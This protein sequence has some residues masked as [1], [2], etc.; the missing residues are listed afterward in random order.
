MTK[1]VNIV[2]FDVPLPANYGG[3]IDVYCKIK[4][5]SDLGVKVHLHCFQYGRGKAIQLESICESVTYYNRKKNIIS[6]FSQ[7][8][9]IV[10][11]R[12]NKELLFNLAE[13]DF[14]ILFEGLHTTFFLSS[15]KLRDRVKLVRTHN[16]EHDYYKGLFD[17]ER[18]L[19]RRLFFFFEQKKL[20]KYE[21]NLSSSNS[22]I[23]LSESDFKYF[24]S[25]FSNVNLIN[26]FHV[27]EAISLKYFSQNYVFYHA[28]LSISENI[29]ALE[30]L[31]DEV[32]SSIN[33]PII[34]AGKNPSKDLKDKISKYN[35]IKLIESPEEKVMGLLKE[36]A[37]VHILYTHQ[38]TG[39]KLKLIDSL[40]CNAHCIVNQKMISGTKLD[41]AC[42]VANS[43]GEIIDELK[44]AW[45]S[46]EVK[47]LQKR[48]EL[49][50]SN[51][52]NNN[53][54]KL[55]LSILVQLPRG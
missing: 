29:K 38:S 8:P 12:S 44:L 40:F 13:N 25:R 26:V 7:I 22:I 54:A 9:F 32:F 42:I 28:N 5:L 23:T 21:S 1:E 14:P 18:N 10:K 4:A 47:G 37:S 55:I 51:Y 33:Y 48:R 53:N 30:Y 34:I 31:I 35:N 45:E 36:E 49:L 50:L 11:T 46:V 15:D 3:V 6:F 52:S 16:V 27:N 17:S 24:S 2:S 41:S 20:K 43:S 19:L 39:V